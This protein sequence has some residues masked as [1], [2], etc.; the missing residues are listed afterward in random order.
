MANGLLRLLFITPKVEA[1]KMRRLEM[2]L[3]INFTPDRSDIRRDFGKAAASGSA[4]TR[5]NLET[6]ESLY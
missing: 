5:H 6:L 3:H 1:V 4:G 2:T